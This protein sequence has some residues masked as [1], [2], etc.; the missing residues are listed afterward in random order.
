VYTSAK[1]KPLFPL[2]TLATWHRPRVIE[3]ARALVEPNPARL[4]P[5]HGK[6]VESPVAAM[7]AAIAKAGG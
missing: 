4:A 1:V 3:S 6:V 5:G 7:E 2:P